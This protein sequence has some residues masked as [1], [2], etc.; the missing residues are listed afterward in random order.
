MTTQGVR[1][2]LG[3]ISIPAASSSDQ[4]RWAVPPPPPPPPTSMRGSPRKWSPVWQFFQ[5]L[6]A[7]PKGAD[8]PFCRFKGSLF[9]SDDSDRWQPGGWGWTF[10][11]VETRLKWCSLCY[12]LFLEEVPKNCANSNS[13][14]G[15]IFAALPVNI[16]ICWTRSFLWRLGSVLVH[17]TRR[18]TLAHVPPRLTLPLCL[19][20]CIPAKNGVPVLGLFGYTKVSFWCSPCRN[21]CPQGLQRATI[22]PQ[23][24]SYENNH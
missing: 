7:I 17:Y 23:L 1:D 20:S 4:F 6:S 14:P 19:L 9:L 3:N 12:N 11:R 13:Y 15:P 5:P 21:K 18:Q 22:I 2:G 10:V 8:E 16:P 24:F